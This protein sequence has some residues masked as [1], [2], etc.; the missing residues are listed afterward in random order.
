M[1]FHAPPNWSAKT[2]MYNIKTKGSDS[3]P[4]SGGQYI[5]AFLKSKEVNIARFE[6]PSEVHLN[7]EDGLISKNK[8]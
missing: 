7:S 4:G 2:R 1:A 6:P 3:T 8:W 5:K